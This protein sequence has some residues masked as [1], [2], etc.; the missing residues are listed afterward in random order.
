MKQISFYLLI[1]LITSCSTPKE[2][3]KQTAYA[4]E[5][6]PSYPEVNLVEESKENEDSPASD[7]N[8]TKG[9][10][11]DVYRQENQDQVL[12]LKRPMDEAWLL[13]GQAIRLN[14]LEVISKNRK[15]RLYKVEYK[16]DSLFGGFTLFGSGKPSIYLLKLESQNN[17]TQLSVSKK[18][19]STETDESLLKDGAP[20]F[21]NDNSAKL[22]NLLFEGLQEIISN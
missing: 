3:S 17:V 7:R 21:S 2:L 15:Q 10:P 13:V 20:E 19:D 8:F 1:A 5:K 16:G 18:E 4:L 11:N 6:P 22:T 12:W 14:K 9:P